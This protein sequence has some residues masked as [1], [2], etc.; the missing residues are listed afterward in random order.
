M[1]GM[2]RWN[3]TQNLVGVEYGSKLNPQR[4]EDGINGWEYKSANGKI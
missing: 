2:A 1:L 3:L 4:N